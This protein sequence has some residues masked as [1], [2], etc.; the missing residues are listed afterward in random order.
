[1]PSA[2]KAIPA[3][4]EA[5]RPTARREYESFDNYQHA[6]FVVPAGTAFV[7]AIQFSGLPERLR[8]RST[9][10]G[11]QVRL[12]NPGEPPQDPMAV[13]VSEITNIPLGARIVECRDPGGAGGGTISITGYWPSRAIDKRTSRRGP[14][15]SDVRP[16][17]QGAPEQLEPR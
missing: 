10:N 7:E 8:V 11:Y 12:R 9:N 16:R 6:D 15:A 1:V 4:R 13:F 14:L 5:E 17:E 3:R 2:P